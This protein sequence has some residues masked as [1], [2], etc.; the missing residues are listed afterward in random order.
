MDQVF[1]VVLFHLDFLEDHLFFLGNVI[2]VKSRVQHQVGEHIDGHGKMLVEHFG[3]EAGHFLGRKRVQH[4][5]HRIH[6]LRD[7]L[8]GAFARALEHHVL[9]EVRDPVALRRFARAIP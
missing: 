2:G 7:F 3:V 5:A 9:D 6:R 8:G 4:P 1:R